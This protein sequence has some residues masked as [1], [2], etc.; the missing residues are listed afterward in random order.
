M[1]LP[2]ENA[3][4]LALAADNAVM[5]AESVALKLFEGRLPRRIARILLA[6]G[7]GAPEHLL[8]MPMGRIATLPGMSAAARR[9][10][11]AY[12]SRFIPTANV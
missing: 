6:A 3:R 7:I 9:E 2:D 4:L 5:A 12:R 11:Q 1:S 10:I 8:F